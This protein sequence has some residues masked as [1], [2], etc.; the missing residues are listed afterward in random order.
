MKNMKNS[1]KVI[2]AAVAFAILAAPAAY[3]GAV[4]NYTG[5]DGFSAEPY[6][7]GTNLIHIRL[8]SN[9]PG[10]STGNALMPGINLTTALIEGLDFGIGGGLNFNSIGTP[11]NNLSVGAVYPWIRAA[12]PLG[13][14]NVKTGIMVGTSIP[15]NT[16]ANPQNINNNNTR[17]S[18]EFFPGVSGLVDVYLGQLTNSAFPLTM[19]INAGYARGMSSGTNLLSANL[20]FTLP[21]AGLQIYE[22]Q[23]V[24]VPVGNYS[25][26]GIRL[27]V[28]IP[29]GDRFVF[30]IK[31]A[32]LW[33]S[34]STGTSWTFNPSV[35]A[36]MRF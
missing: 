8:D 22:E 23:F 34:G 11:L 25:N 5:T 20:N 4:T 31:P 3:A 14:E 35:G 17:T 30:D 29:V 6:L 7:P 10:F 13:I 27:G 15:I 9:F 33:D 32:A 21:Y 2:F 28:N 18:N 26:G 24:N 1:K 12:V 19:G 36:S 16:T